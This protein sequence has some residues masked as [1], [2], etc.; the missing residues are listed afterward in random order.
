MLNCWSGE[1]YKVMF[2]VSLK[3]HDNIDTSFFFFS[4]IFLISFLLSVIT[5]LIWEVYLVIDDVLKKIMKSG[6]MN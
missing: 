1:L 5:G 6:M 3:V 2:D 4:F